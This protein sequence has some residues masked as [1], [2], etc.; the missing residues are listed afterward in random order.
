[1]SR[2]AKRRVIAP[3][4]AA[5]PQTTSGIL[6][7]VAPVAPVDTAPKVHEVYAPE[8][9]TAP[10]VTFFG[11][12]SICMSIKGKIYGVS[13]PAERGHTYK[14]SNPV[15]IEALRERGYKEKA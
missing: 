1:M 2:R 3:I 14:T 8:V 11:T 9:D 5:A 12:G 6:L 13:F 15:I 10:V 4:A 7:A